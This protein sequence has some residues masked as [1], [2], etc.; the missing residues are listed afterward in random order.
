MKQVIV[1]KQGDLSFANYL[2]HFSVMFW[3]CSGLL[4]ERGS[5]V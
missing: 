5:P 2:L 3:G 1:K 4:C